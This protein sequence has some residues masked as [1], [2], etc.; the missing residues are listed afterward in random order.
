MEPSTK[1]WTAEGK[2]VPV[3][4]ILNQ[5]GTLVDARRRKD[6]TQP[7]NSTL[8]PAN[9]MNFEKKATRLVRQSR[10]GREHITPDTP[11][12]KRTVEHCFRTATEDVLWQ[13][14]MRNLDTAFRRFTN[15]IDL[16][17]EQR[18]H[19]A[20]DYL[21]RVESRRK[22]SAIWFGTPKER[23]SV[24]VANRLKDGRTRH[25]GWFGCQ[26]SEVP[27]CKGEP[28]DSGFTKARF[29]VNG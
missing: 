20:L 16:Y 1:R 3:V 7:D 11:E 19:S 12:R 10:V 13:Y 14:S 26:H 22:Q 6:L 18:P 28:H 2:A 25:I 5:E 23:L 29:L 9:Y 15:R 4:E 8:R 24:L 17:E 21:S 27:A